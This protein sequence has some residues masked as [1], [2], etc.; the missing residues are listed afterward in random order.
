MTK[1]P[2][3]RKELENYLNSQEGFIK[4]V[5]IFVVADGWGFSPETCGRALRQL[6]EEGKIQVSYYDGK[7]AKNLAMYAR[8]GEVQ[9]K[10]KVQLVEIDGRLVAQMI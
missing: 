8:K 4:K 6:A 2:N 3:L 1:R 10:P 9:V 5:H 7:W